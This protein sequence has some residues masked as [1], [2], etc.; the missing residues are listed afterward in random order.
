MIVVFQSFSRVRLF[1]TLWTAARQASLY[2]TNA[3]SLLKLMSIESVMPSKHLILCRPLLLLSNFLS[4]RVFS[5]ESA[6]PIR[7]PK[8]W[9]FSF[10][11]STLNEYSGFISFRIHWFDPLLSK[12]LLG[13]FSNTIVQ[14]Y[15][16]FGAQPFLWSNSHIHT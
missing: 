14:K 6:L 9:G 13:V 3:W 2:F 1:A 10:S 12:G 15:Q 8:Y 7:W 5:R 4:I 16:F 11:N